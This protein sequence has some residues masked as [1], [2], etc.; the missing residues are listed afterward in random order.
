MVNKTGE[1]W[2][3]TELYRLKGEL[4]LKQRAKGEKTKDRRQQTVGTGLALPT[5]DT[6]SNTLTDEVE[7]CFYQ[8]LDIARHN[9]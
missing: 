3:E 2:W 9:R 8:A 7:A 6:P 4:L 1:C 5:A